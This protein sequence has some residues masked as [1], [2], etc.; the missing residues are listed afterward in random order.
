MSAA[1]M[2]PL[3]MLSKR[4]PVNCAIA[5][6]KEKDGVILLDKK[7]KP[8]K[9]MA[10]LKKAAG[11]AGV[12]LDMQT[13]RYGTAG[14]DTD[15]DAG[16]VSFKVNKEAPGTMRPK[17]LQTLKKAGFG[18]CEIIVDETLDNESD[19]DTAAEATDGPAATASAPDDA[20]AGDLAAAASPDAPPTA[21]AEPP[22][23]TDTAAAA[24]PSATPP[25]AA[26]APAAGAADASAITTR[27]AGLVRQLM[28][29]M[30]SNPPGAD[31]MRTA[32]LGAQTSLKSGDL[33]AATQQADTLERMLSGAAS[34]PAGGA[35][36]GGAA[37][38]MGSPVFDKARVTWTATCKKIE[39]E[40]GKLHAEITSVYK[41]HGVAADLDKMF[42]S[43]V[44]P[45]M[46]K[47][48]DG[49]SKKLDEVSKNSDPAAHQ[50][51]VQ[52]ARQMISTY[53]G[54]LASED[55][56]AKLDKN[57]FTPLAIEKTLTATLT[58]LSKA[59]V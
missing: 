6:T 10:Q 48:D 44:V 13:I 19:D 41:G 53:E 35:A 49:L 39:S 56:I 2:K 5:L 51:L 32:A 15:V 22:G 38:T 55:L 58:A 12:A 16:L 9:L 29:L 11:D 28:T 25:P 42:Q 52:E 14:V 21:A 47:F 26:A 20:Q 34:A 50:K 36:A 24:P 33:A 54:Y 3:L 30:P 59:I 18:K 37:S 23:A 31:A 1:E 17:L 4:N 46:S 43:K 45:M 8:R 40:I 7:G 27:L 57:P